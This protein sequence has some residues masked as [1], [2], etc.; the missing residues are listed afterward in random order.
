M[1]KHSFAAYRRPITGH[2]LFS[3]INATIFI[4]KFVKNSEGIEIT[5][6]NSIIIVVMQ[7]DPYMTYIH[8]SS[9]K[10]TNVKKGCHSQC[11]R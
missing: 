9:V 4:T 8:K 6:T 2:S 3:H 11:K 10:T 1:L 7:G 5:G